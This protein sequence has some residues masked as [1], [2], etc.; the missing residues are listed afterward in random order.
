MQTD[1]QREMENLR[2]ET[3]CQI[4]VPGAREGADPSGRAEIKLKGTKKQVEEA[5][6][7]LQQRAKVFDDTVVETLDVVPLGQSSKQSSTT[8][9]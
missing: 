5:K 6:K 2:L 1:P 9:R 3:G 4:D 8:S 7:I